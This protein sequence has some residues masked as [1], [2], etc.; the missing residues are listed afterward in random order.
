MVLSNTHG[1]RLPRRLQLHRHPPHPRAARVL[2][3]R[4]RHQDLQLPRGLHA[5]GGQQRR[6]PAGRRHRERGAVQDP[7]DQLHR[8]P[9]DHQGR[10]PVSAFGASVSCWKSLSQANVRSP[11]QFTF[12]GHDHRPAARR[13]PDRQPELADPGDAELARHAAAVSGPLRAGHVE[14]VAQGHVELRPALGAGLGAADSQRRD[15]QLQRRSLPRGRTHHAVRECAA[16]DS[17][18]PATRASPTT[19]PA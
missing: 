10:P 4:R 5:A 13:L 7:V 12:N 14:V 1:Q 9:D 15:L 2:A 8:R 11:G 6:L 19:R 17:S 18:I 16:R 3:H